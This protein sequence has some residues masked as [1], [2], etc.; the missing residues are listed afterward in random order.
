MSLSIG[1]GMSANTC[2][3]GQAKKVGI[4]SN[5]QDAYNGGLVGAQGRWV[6]WDLGAGVWGW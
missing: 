6:S 3:Q 2:V 5:S 4:H 1:M